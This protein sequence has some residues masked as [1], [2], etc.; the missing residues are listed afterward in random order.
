MKDGTLGAFAPASRKQT[1]LTANTVLGPSQLS[2]FVFV[3]SGANPVA[4]TLPPLDSINPGGFYYLAQ[5]SGTGA[6]TV[7]PS[8][9]DTYN[10]GGNTPVTVP[11]LDQGSLL[12]LR[13]AGE[14][15]I[16]GTSQAQ[17][18]AWDPSKTYWVDVG[19]TG[20][21]S[22]GSPS[23]PFTSIQEAIDLAWAEV[24]SQAF[25]NYATVIVA[26]GEYFED[27]LLFYPFVT[28]IGYDADSTMISSTAPVDL[29]S[30][31]YY[32]LYNL[33]FLTEWAV[34]M[35]SV[36]F[37]GWYVWCRTWNC[38]WDA[39]FQTNGLGANWHWFEH[40]EA[41]FSGGADMDLQNVTWWMSDCTVY[42]SQMEVKSTAGATQPFT[43]KDGNDYAT[44]VYLYDGFS[45]ADIIGSQPSGNDGSWVELAGR[46]FAACTMDA[47][48]TA[49]S[50][51]ETTADGYPEDGL[52]LT[53]G[54]VQY[55]S[56][57]ALGLLY[58]PTTPTDWANPPPETVGE[59]IDRLAAA[60]P[61]A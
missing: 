54:A 43:G 52:V 30:F 22:D 11:T 2:G 29:F 47:G 53:N 56:G 15:V 50:T 18:S 20:G 27:A 34:P 13:G 46:L 31:G 61:G 19:Y 39:P 7:Q 8:T 40:H 6:V 51:V 60:N 21:V 41:Y 28:V 25:E 23:R 42:A 1:T 55:P 12:V 45:T 3:D 9:G 14:W 57:N 26:P 48:G 10:N 32:N 4:L 17:A 16:V 35:T 49:I 38:R 59:A 5:R 33:R 58:D 36:P 37:F 44:G 24:S